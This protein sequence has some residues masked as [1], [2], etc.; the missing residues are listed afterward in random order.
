MTNSVYVAIVMILFTLLVTN[1]LSIPHKKT[2]TL[3]VQN[4]DVSH[5]RICSETV[6]ISLVSS[7]SIA[8][9]GETVTFIAT[10]WYGPGPSGNI[11]F[12]V[13]G[14]SIGTVPISDEQQAQISTKFSTKGTHRV[15]AAYQG[16]DYFCPGTTEISQGVTCSPNRATVTLISDLNP[17]LP[18]QS[19]RFQ[20]TVN[21]LSATGSVTFVWNGLPSN[22]VSQAGVLSNGVATWDQSFP[23]GSQSITAT[24]EGDATYCISDTVGLTQIVQQA[25]GAY[26]PATTTSPTTSPRANSTTASPSETNPIGQQPGPVIPATTTS[27]TTMSPPITSTT[28]SP[29]ETNST[30]QELSG[31]N[32]AKVASSATS[33]VT[34]TGALI[35]SAVLL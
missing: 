31:E 30:G 32:N 5:L 18:G 3:I 20:A 23:T 26:I 35:V 12:S 7:T 33:L 9:L 25:Q 19:V 10:I 24:Y 28:A 29:S 21:P 2:E 27:P 14:N 34:L 8:I 6:T 1:V 13:D 15:V 22:Y 16:D 4:K 11:V 17:A